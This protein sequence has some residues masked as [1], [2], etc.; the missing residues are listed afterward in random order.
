MWIVKRCSAHRE[1]GNA[2]LL[3]Q[4]LHHQDRWAHLS[5]IMLSRQYKTTIPNQGKQS[6]GIWHSGWLHAY[7]HLGI[8][9]FP[10]NKSAI[11]CKEQNV[12][13]WLWLINCGGCCD[14]AGKNGFYLHRTDLTYLY[15][16]R[17]SPE[18]GWASITNRIDHVSD[19][20][21]PGSVVLCELIR[22]FHSVS[23]RPWSW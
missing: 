22:H 8:I 17:H 11:L 23:D 4:R 15:L 18:E 1:R 20:S 2:S 16:C 7:I 9:L 10:R 6:V 21:T 3:A 14:Y 19:G 13:I 5:V 12:D